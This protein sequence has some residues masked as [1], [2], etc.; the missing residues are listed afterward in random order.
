MSEV[1]ARAVAE[2][3]RI[4]IQTM[5]EAWAQR[6]HDAS[7]PKIGR[8]AMRQLMFNW[9]AKDKYSELKAFRLEV[10]N[11]LS[12]CNTP[13]TDKLVVDKNCLGRRGLQY[14]ET[15][16]TVEKEMCNTQKGLFET[17]SNKFKPKYKM[18]IK[19]P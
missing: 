7:G 3:T 11:V 2:A 12:M 4:T 16:R 19:P 17:V 10:N 5:A 13:Q 18:T 15:L 9:N 8:P 6:L 14:L 1:I